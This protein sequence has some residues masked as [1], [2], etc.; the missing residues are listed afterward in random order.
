MS[1][2]RSLHA[3]LRAVDEGDV[4]L[5]R[6]LLAEQPALARGADEAGCTALMLTARFD[7]PEIARLLIDAGADLGALDTVHG[8]TALAWAA[9]YGS[10]PIVALL[11]DAGADV[12][13]INPYGLD[14]AQ[15][16]QGG[17]RGEHAA[18][19]PERCPEDFL[20]IVE[21]LAGPSPSPPNPTLT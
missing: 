11:V 2:E 18:D 3:L 7:R 8:S 20:A 5:A 6:V 19:A 9:Y 13:H 17:A 12:H 21:L 1:A 15:I 14:P 4:D 16:A 10:L